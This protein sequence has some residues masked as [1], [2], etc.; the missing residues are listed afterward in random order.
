MQS[1]N[2]KLLIFNE[3]WG[4]RMLCH[5]SSFMKAQRIMQNKIPILISVLNDN[6]YQLLLSYLYRNLS[7]I[8]VKKYLFLISMLK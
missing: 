6:D 3:V 4:M 8:F 2:N 5:S 1:V 7:N